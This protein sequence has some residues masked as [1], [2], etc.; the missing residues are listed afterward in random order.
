MAVVLMAVALMAEATVMVTAAVR[1]QVAM[2]AVAMGVTA[3]GG[4]VRKGAFAYQKRAEMD[5]RARRKSSPSTS[6]RRIN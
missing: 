2:I 6:H 5:F 3:G 1:G 4:G